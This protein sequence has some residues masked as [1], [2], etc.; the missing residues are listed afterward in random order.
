MQSDPATGTAVHV[1]AGAVIGS[2]GG[3]STFGPEGPDPP[4]PPEPPEPPVPVVAPPVPGPVVGDVV[5]LAPPAPPWPE[6]DPPAPVVVGPLE[7][8]F[9]D[10][11][12]SDEPQA[13]AKA[14]RKSPAAPRAAIDKHT[15][16]VH[17]RGWGTEHR[18]TAAGDSTR[19][20][21]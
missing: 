7:P 4:P 19:I 1:I 15:F 11:L 17:P 10:G 2:P 16:M 8:G 3:T 14:N 18:G 12:D 5:V 9:G 6:L 20:F 13:V 21:A